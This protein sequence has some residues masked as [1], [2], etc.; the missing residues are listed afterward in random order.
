MI[1]QRTGRQ[2]NSRPLVQ[3]K[4]PTMLRSLSTQLRLIV[5]ALTLTFLLTSAMS[6]PLLVEASDPEADVVALTTY[7]SR[8]VEQVEAT[9]VLASQ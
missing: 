4:R 9:R 1:A 7:L 8:A 2:K 5:L 3:E 6:G